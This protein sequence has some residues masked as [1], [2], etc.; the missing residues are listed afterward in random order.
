MEEV[1]GTEV[2]SMLQV[3]LLVNAKDIRSTVILKV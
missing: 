2:K 3:T 1:T